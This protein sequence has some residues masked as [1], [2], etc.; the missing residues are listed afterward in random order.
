MIPHDSSLS[1]S[2]SLLLSAAKEEDI[3]VG[4]G[5]WRSIRSLVKEKENK[6]YV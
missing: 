5:S 3:S 4:S 1:L 6:R 2:P